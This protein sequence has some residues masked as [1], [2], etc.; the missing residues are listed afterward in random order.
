M[1][2]SSLKAYIFIATTAIGSIL[3]LHQT[4]ATNNKLTLTNIRVKN[5]EADQDKHG[6]ILCLMAL[7]QGVNE[8][9]LRNFCDLNP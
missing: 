5:I 9:D 6:K 7:K 8:N 2:L 3:Y 1:S 4:F